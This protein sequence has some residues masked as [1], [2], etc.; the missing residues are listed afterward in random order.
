METYTFGKQR[1][2]KENKSGT[3]AGRFSLTTCLWFVNVHFLPQGGWRRAGRGA[4][5][6]DCLLVGKFHA[7]CSRLLI[8]H[9]L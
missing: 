1:E 5:G 2:K 7:R 6:A 8:Q 9:R 3:K 4:L